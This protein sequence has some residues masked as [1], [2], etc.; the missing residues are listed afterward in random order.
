MRCVH[1]HP[2]AAQVCAL[3]QLMAALIH[4]AYDLLSQQCQQ[5]QHGFAKPNLP[6]IVHMTCCSGTLQ[7]LVALQNCKFGNNVILRNIL[8]FYCSEV[9]QNHKLAWEDAFFTVAEKN[10]C[11]RDT[12]FTAFRACRTVDNAPARYGMDCGC[13]WNSSLPER[14][15]RW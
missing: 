4:K 3:L 10:T 6:C 7:P 8:L 2:F 11:S 15:D 5:C 12:S 9:R 14:V 13:W 1:M